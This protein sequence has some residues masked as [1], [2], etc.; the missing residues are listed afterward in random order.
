MTKSPKKGSEAPRSPKT[1]IGYAKKLQLYVMPTLGLLR[2]D[3][4]EPDH[5]LR[6]HGWMAA[7]RVDG[8]GIILGKGKGV[9]PRTIRATHLVLRAALND[10]KLWNLIRWNPAKAVDPPAIPQASKY[11]P[12]LLSPDQWRAAIVAADRVW[13]GAM[14]VLAAMMGLRRGEISALRWSDI[15]LDGDYPWLWV[16]GS[17]Q[18]VKGEGLVRLP[19][20]N[21]TSNRQIAI[22]AVAAAFLRAIRRD[23]GFVITNNDKDPV[24]PSSAYRRSWVVLRERIGLPATARLHD[25]RHFV[26]THQ[27]LKEVLPL[28]L[29]SAYFGHAVTGTTLSIYVG[30]HLRELVEG[31]ATLLREESRKVAAAIDGIYAGSG[32]L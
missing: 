8:E 1:T 25:L 9:K 18:S 13:G 16:S 6:L 26:A 30:P 28:A 5:I 17:L 32:D 21:E 22:P 14:P 2:L 12:K 24:E 23:S 11:Q 4:L 31:N 10:A 15:Y 29:Q 27:H 3:Q 20:K 7:G 19:P